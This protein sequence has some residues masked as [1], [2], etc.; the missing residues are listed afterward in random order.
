VTRVDHRPVGEGVMG[1][2]VT[3]LR[4]LF[5]EVVRGRVPKYRHWNEPVY[6]SVPAPAV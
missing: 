6:A 4:H 3:Q 2:I 5:N 1:P